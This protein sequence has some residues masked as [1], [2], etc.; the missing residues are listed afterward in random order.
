MVLWV[1]TASHYQ[2]S[3]LCNCC[4]SLVWTVPSRTFH[5]CK[6]WNARC[7]SCPTQL[8]SITCLLVWSHAWRGGGRVRRRED[9][10]GKWLPSICDI[11]R[12][13]AQSEARK[14][15]P[16]SNTRLWQA[17]HPASSE[18]DGEG[19]VMDRA[20]MDSWPSWEGLVAPNKIVKGGICN[21]GRNTACRMYK[22]CVVRWRLWI[23]YSFI[24]PLTLLQ[25]EYLF[26]KPFFH[27]LKPP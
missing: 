2:T 1:V 5:L 19:R 11:D 18:G 27:F 25:L 22:L 8:H 12:A 15:E 14:D 6:P 20:M 7:L 24:I 17:E 10:V 13:G 16:S 9:G 26:S 21:L 23:I 4:E 3:A